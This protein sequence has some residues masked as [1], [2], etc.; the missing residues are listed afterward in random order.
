MTASDWKMLGRVTVGVGVFGIGAMIGLVALAGLID[1][2]G[3]QMA[4][5]ADPFG[6][7]TGIIVPIV[8]LVGGCGAM[9]AGGWWT[10]RRKS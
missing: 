8:L 1:P 10:T 6:K 9:A 3:A 7:P 5:D 4:N 2:A